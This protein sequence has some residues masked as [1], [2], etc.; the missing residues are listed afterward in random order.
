MLNYDYITLNYPNSVSIYFN[1]KCS[2]RSQ[3]HQTYLDSD[4]KLT[5]LYVNQCINY[6]TIFCGKT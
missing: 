5:K 3:T 4:S 6:S 2:L 1:L